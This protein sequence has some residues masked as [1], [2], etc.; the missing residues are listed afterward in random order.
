MNV[1]C[2]HV[3]LPCQ[4]KSNIREEPRAISLGGTGLGN[5]H[6][7]SGRRSVPRVICAA[8]TG[9]RPDSTVLELHKNKYWNVINLSDVVRNDG[10][11]YYLL[12]AKLGP[13]FF[14]LM[15]NGT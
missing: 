5:L 10:M 8:Q 14:I 11:L 6:S 3:N 2:G 12:S 1:S 15:L 9:T 13:G 7:R 4:L